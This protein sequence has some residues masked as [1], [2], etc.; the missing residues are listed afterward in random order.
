MTN[1]DVC[2]AFI[3]GKKRTG[4]HIYTDGKIIYSYGSHHPLGFIN[5]GL[6]LVNTDGYSSTTRRH[7]RCLLT[8]LDASRNRSLRSAHHSN[9]VEC[10]TKEI[11]KAIERPDLPLVLYRIPEDISIDK[12]LQI[13]KEQ[14]RKKGKKF[15]MKK[16]N[17]LLTAEMV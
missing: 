14:Y 3:L 15:P 7:K 10:T 1:E 2:N 9:I 8:V 17:M 13:M 6:V 5:N 12:L 11:Q 4:K 16:I